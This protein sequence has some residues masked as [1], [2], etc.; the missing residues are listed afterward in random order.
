MIITKPK[1]KNLIRKRISARR[2]K[3]L[4]AATAIFAEKGIDNTTIDEIAS[5]AGVG[6]GTIY[7]QTGNKENIIKI[8]LKEA[9]ILV[10]ETIREKIKK[11]K[12]PVFQFKE[13]VSALCDIYENH[14]ELMTLAVTQIAL[15]IEQCKNDKNKKSNIHKEVFKLFEILGKIIRK[16]IKTKQFKQTD[17]LLIAAGFFDFLNP[18]SYQFLRLERQYTKGEIAQMVTDLFLNGLRKK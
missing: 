9:V 4:K 1:A 17:T 16:G 5:L 14:L 13:A 11:K 12:D 3:I 7:R 8:L 15:C 18:S 10:A 6:K 2:E